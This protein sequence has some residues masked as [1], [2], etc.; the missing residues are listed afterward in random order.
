MKKSKYERGF[1]ESAGRKNMAMQIKESLYSKNSNLIRSDMAKE[2]FL[3]GALSGFV[4]GI[5][6]V[7]A[8]I[9]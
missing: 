8:F 6:I 1:R 3:I 7:G 5:I 2:Y 4:A 9:T